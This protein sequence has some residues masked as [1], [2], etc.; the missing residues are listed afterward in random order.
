MTL[1]FENES[2]DAFPFDCEALGNQIFSA[3]MD[4]VNCPYEAEVSLL[5]TTS[6]TI[7]EINLEKRNINRPTDVLSFPMNDFP[8]AGDFAFL[9][10]EPWA[11]HPESG[12]LLLGDII[13][14]AA[15]IKSQAAEYGHSEKREFAFL[16]VHSLLHLIG[17]DHVLQEEAAIM[18]EIQKNFLDFLGIKRT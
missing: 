5:L 14:S 4:Y 10:D 13:I 12:E 9:E 16:M 1:Y 8:I 17:Y 3:F 2:K 6:Q 11:F 18:E 15:H 7:C